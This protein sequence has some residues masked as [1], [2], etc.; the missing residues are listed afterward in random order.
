MI[1]INVGKISNRVN[2]RVTLKNPHTNSVIRVYEFN[3]DDPQT[4]YAHS[5]L[6]IEIEE[7]VP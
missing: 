7:I 3:T 1:N 2:V 5:E 4:F 6:K